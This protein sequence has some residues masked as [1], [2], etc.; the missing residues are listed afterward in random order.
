MSVTVRNSNWGGASGNVS[1]LLVAYI[2]DEI[3][4]LEP[5]LQYA[6]LGKRKDAPKGFD[7]ILFPQ[8][9]QLPVKVNVNTGPGQG[10]ITTFGS[11]VGG[12]VGG[13]VYSGVDTLLPSVTTLY[14][15]GTSNVPVSSS[16]GVAAITEGTNPTAVTWGATSYGS[17][18]F[19]YGI[20]V[21]VSDLLVHNSAIEVVDSCT[22]QVRNALA[23]QVDTTL[24][25]V[26][27]SGVNGIVYAGGKTSRSGLGAGDL[28]TQNEMTKAV[29]NLRSANAAGL[30][31]F[32]GSYYVAVIHP[33]VMADLMSN[34]GSGSWIDVGRYTSIDELKKGSIGDFRGVRYFESAYQNVF[35]STTT[36]F[37]TTVLGDESFGWGYFQQPTPIL[38]TTPDSNNPLNLY[39]S[40]GGKVTLGASRTFLRHSASNERN[41]QHQCSHTLPPL[42]VGICLYLMQLHTP[43]RKLKLTQMVSL[44]LMV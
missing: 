41:L 27:N 20:L 40:I 38:V 6:R 17:G 43:A 25:T 1:E 26:V 18:P 15:D 29:R 13:S 8:T 44:I 3:K 31:P 36:V 24:Q 14:G 34:T 30:K 33:Y 28:L 21:Q 16:F 10:S 39:T 42:G 9:N 35:S 32:D 37:P 4:V 7:R 23:R 19:Q 5:Q 11:V 22:M 12:G 2:S